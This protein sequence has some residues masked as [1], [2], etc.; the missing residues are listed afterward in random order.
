MVVVGAGRGSKGTYV[1]VVSAGRG[2]GRGRVVVVGAG[3]G[4]GE[5]VCSR[6]TSFEGITGDWKGPAHPNIS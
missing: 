3:R 1:V 6:R 5:R 2:A 4:S